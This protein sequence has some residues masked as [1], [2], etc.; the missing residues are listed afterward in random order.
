[1]AEA[2]LARIERQ[3]WTSLA[4][5]PNQL[6]FLQDPGRF[7]LIRQGNQFGGKTTALLTDLIW[8]LLGDH[9]YLEVPP[10]PVEWYLVCA[11]AGQS[12]VVQ[13]KLWDL[14]PKHILDPR[15]DFDE[16]IG[17][18]GRRPALRLDNGSICHIKTENQKGKALASATLDGVAIDEPP[19][20]LRK[21]TELRKRV[22]RKNGKVT[23]AMT[24]AN[25]G[26]LEWMVNEVDKGRLNDHHTRMSAPALVPVGRSEPI[27]LDDGTPCGEAWVA[28]EIAATP[29]YERPVVCH[30]EWE[31]R[32]VDRM[33][34]A[35]S[36]GA[37]VS[38]APPSGISRLHLGVDYGSKTGKQYACLLA[39]QPGDVAIHDRLHVLDETPVAEHSTLAE[40]AAAVL[41][42]L[43]RNGLEWTDLDEMWGDRS[44]VRGSDSKSNAELHR[45]ICRLL[46]RKTGLT[47]N[48]RTVKRGEGRGAGSVSTGIRYLHRIQAAGRFSVHPR[49]ARMIAALDNWDGRRVQ[50]RS[51]G[52][53][54]F[55]DSFW[56]DPIDALRYG[57]ES[58]I[59]GVM[60]QPLPQV[61]L[62]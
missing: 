55:V 16:V 24:P 58:R 34:R 33:F 47:R 14:V 26:N 11:E 57:L 61:R 2:T 9:P 59:F 23:V 5:L 1:M 8:H 40:D 48:I 13:Q 42:M 38:A 30:G 22:M 3:P 28:R 12:I 18:R 36:M 7:R 43:S 15:C 44:Y 4:W 10:A 39:V 20:S 27:E 49:C 21:Y 6:A 56:K 41:G 35:W 51:S 50:T 37:M 60:T 32:T 29:E 52:G 19:S 54:V 17:F 45:E 62:G 31:Y 25:A 46:K 53:V